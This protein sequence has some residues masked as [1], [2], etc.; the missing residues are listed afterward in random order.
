MALSTPSPT[1][2]PEALPAPQT[3]SRS[4]KNWSAERAW[5]YPADMRTLLGLAL[6]LVASSADA[7][8]KVEVQHL[9]MHI[10]GG[11]ND[12][13]TKAPFWA[14]IAAHHADFVA[15]WSLL[16]S[17]GKVD[18]SIDA[19]VPGK[20]GLA[21]VDRPRSTAKAPAFVAC[22]QGVYER[23]DF[24]PP[25]SGVPTKVSASLRLTARP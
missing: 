2:A 6:L 14:S 7:S 23:L 3:L 11:P 4:R 19:L 22:M 12:D 1:S 17:P 15:C 25:K 9:G 21:K 5:G 10:G 16:P 20:G 8:T 18:F 13:A 24:L